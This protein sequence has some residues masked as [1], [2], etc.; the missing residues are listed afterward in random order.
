MA[1]VY[2]H[3]KLTNDEIFYVGKGTNRR[4]K[5]TDERNE[6][7]CRTASKYGWYA[8]KLMDNLSD[9]EAYELEELVCETIG[10]ENLTNIAP[11][12]LGGIG[13]MKS[14]NSGLSEIQ[15]LS[16]ETGIPRRTLHN[17]TKGHKPWKKNK[18]RWK[19]YLKVTELANQGKLLTST[20]EMGLQK[21]KD[22]G[23]K[24]PGH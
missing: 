11:A 5:R 2:L 13:K 22:P 14:W 19:V 3:K 12:G 4:W 7:W 24:V 8:E 9:D 16:E 6:Y 10:Y 23:S 21:Q 18:H 17:W 1:Y 20:R 15:K